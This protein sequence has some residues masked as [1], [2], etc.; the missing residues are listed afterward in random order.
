MA[1]S[2]L[3]VESHAVKRLSH[4]I[5]K[6]PGEPV[7]LFEGSLVLGFLI[8][9]GILNCDGSLLGKSYG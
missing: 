3:R 2:S 7:T 1:L 4:G 8:K 9:M 6:V 5:M